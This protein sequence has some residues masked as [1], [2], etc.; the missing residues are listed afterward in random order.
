MSSPNVSLSE[1]R[2]LWESY[3]YLGLSRERKNLPQNKSFNAKHKSFKNCLLTRCFDACTLPVNGL[4]NSGWLPG[5]GPE[6][7]EW[8]RCRNPQTDKEG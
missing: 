4:I 8:P 7:E 2:G 1:S 5:I 3:R 6:V